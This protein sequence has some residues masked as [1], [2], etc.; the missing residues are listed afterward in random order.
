MRRYL[1]PGSCSSS[2]RSSRFGSSSPSPDLLPPIV[3]ENPDRAAFFFG[4][5]VKI[6]K[7]IWEWF[8]EG[9]IYQHLWVTLQETA[10][11]F[12]IGSVLGLA[13]GPVARALAH[14]PRRSSTPYITRS[15]PCRAWCWRRS[16]WS[17]SA[18]HL[19]EGGARRDAVFFIVFFQRLPGREGSEP[20][21]SSTTP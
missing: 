3:W 6:F 13:G 19:V 5:P 20:R 1:W 2:S 10:L 7:V 21:W 17:G 9:A 18:R 12:V 4:E 11:A 15:T 8:S 14:G 16:S